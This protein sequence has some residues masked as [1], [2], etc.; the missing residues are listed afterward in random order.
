MV[1]CEIQIYEDGA[2]LT[3]DDQGE[4]VLSPESFAGFVTALDKAYDE[5]VG[6]H[7]CHIFDPDE[8]EPEWEADGTHTIDFA[9]DE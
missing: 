8:D 5:G 9:G 3:I 7:S 2:V 1:R 6:H 4:L